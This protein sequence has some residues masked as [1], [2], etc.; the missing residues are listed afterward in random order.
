MPVRRKARAAGQPIGEA[1]CC[2]L[3]G[4]RRTWVTIEI[5][6]CYPDALV[7]ERRSWIAGVAI[8]TPA[9]QDLFVWGGAGPFLLLSEVS[10]RGRASAGRA[11]RPSP[12]RRGRRSDRWLGRS[13]PPL[14]RPARIGQSAAMESSELTGPAPTPGVDVRG[15][16]PADYAACRMLWAELTE[17]HRRIYEDPA[18]GGDDPGVRSTAISPC[19]NE[20]RPGWPTSMAGLSALR[21]CLT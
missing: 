5:S 8:A 13:V 9:I 2:Y 20:W 15:Y 6:C 18:I 1:S 19:R 4:L 14:R 21:A 10:G 11:A 12:S 16:A 3:D 7:W 17:H